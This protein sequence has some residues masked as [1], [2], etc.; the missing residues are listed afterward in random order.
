MLQHNVNAE[1]GKEEKAKVSVPGQ[2]VQ[3]TIPSYRFDSHPPTPCTPEG[4]PANSDIPNV[5]AVDSQLCTDN[6]PGAAIYKHPG[7]INPGEYL[8]QR[9]STNPNKS[10]PTEQASQPAK[11]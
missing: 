9:A 1:R 6:N 4:T 11:D 3:L 10:G 7:S 8:P 5:Y 2:K